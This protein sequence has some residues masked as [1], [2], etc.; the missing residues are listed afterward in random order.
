MCLIDNSLFFTVSYFLHQDDKPNE[1]E[2]KNHEGVAVANQMRMNSD[3]FDLM[4]MNMGYGFS[5]RTAP[6]D[7]EADEQQRD[8]VI[9]RPSSCRPS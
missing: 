9:L 2:Q 4:I 7:D 5:R 6:P 8:P 1:R 3:P